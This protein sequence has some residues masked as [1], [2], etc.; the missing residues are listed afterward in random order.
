MAVGSPLNQDDSDRKLILQLID[1][2]I[3]RVQLFR[4]VT[5]GLE[6]LPVR[7]RDVWGRPLRK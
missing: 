7:G 6:T 4:Y 5:G 3:W 2:T 1:Y